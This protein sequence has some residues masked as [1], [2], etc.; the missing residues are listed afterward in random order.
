MLRNTVVDTRIGT[1][2]A[3]L[4]VA[5]AMFVAVLL[6]P[7]AQAILACEGL[8]DDMCADITD[9]SPDGGTTNVSPTTNVTVTMDE[10]YACSLTNKNFFL[11]RVG[12]TERVPATVTATTLR[13]STLDPV[14]PLMAGAKYKA[15]IR[16]TF[17]DGQGYHL[18]SAE[19]TIKLNSLKDLSASQKDNGN[20]V[21]AFQPASG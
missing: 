10:T 3:V 1:V 21:W 19:C 13:I 20:I 12:T 5:A 9:V 16:P 8:R 18:K 15:T 17:I 14:N 6:A 2:V 11:K 7:H 4:G